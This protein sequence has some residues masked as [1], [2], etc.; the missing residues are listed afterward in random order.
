VVF[1]CPDPPGAEEC[2][3]IIRAVGAGAGLGGAG[4]QVHTHTRMRC[5]THC[6]RGPV[7]PQAPLASMLRPDHDSTLSPPCGSSPASSTD[8]LATLLRAQTPPS[9]SLQISSKEE[10]EG[11]PE[12]PI[13]LFNQRLSGWVPPSRPSSASATCESYSSCVLRHQ[14]VLGSSLHPQLWPWREAEITWRSCKHAMEARPSTCLA[15]GGWCWP[16]AECVGLS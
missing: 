16:G 3:K 6:G 15:R 14:K 8:C 10:E 12:K 7:D 5:C 1:A 4:A 9:P 11:L 13:V 2:L